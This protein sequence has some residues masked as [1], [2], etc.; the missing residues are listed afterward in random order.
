MLDKLMPGWKERILKENVA[1]EDL[2]RQSCASDASQRIRNLQA[3]SQNLAPFERFEAHFDLDTVA[4]DLSLPCDDHPPQGLQPGLGISVDV[5]FTPD[6]WVTIYAQPAVYE[7]LYRQQAEN[8]KNHFI[9]SGPVHWTVRFTP[10]T[11]GNWEY[12]I[13]VHDGAGLDYSPPLGT[14]ALDF[15]VSGQASNSFTRRGFLRVSALDSRYFEFDNGETITR[16]SR[17]RR[18]APMAA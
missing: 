6:H 5:L 12:R 15:S 1:L 4:Q 16:C 10:Q 3:L 13:A 7:Q 9:P 18:S 2:L 8:N 11:S 17:P 14:P